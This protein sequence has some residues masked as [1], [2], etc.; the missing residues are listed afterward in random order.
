M[1][2]VLYSFLLT[3]S[4]AT[5]GHV[6]TVSRVRP[7]VPWLSRCTYVFLMLRCPPTTRL[8]G[9][10]VLPL[11]QR[12]GLPPSWLALPTRTYSILAVGNHGPTVPPIY[13]RRLGSNDLLQLL[14]LYLAFSAGN[15]RRNK[16]YVHCLAAEE[17]RQERR[18]LNNATFP[19]GEHALICTL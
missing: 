19:G 6:R 13:V 8:R 17:E 15:S 10:R 11:L 7:S 3:R 12:P 16:Y 5:S 14:A 18:R 2:V 9:A 1:K 4:L